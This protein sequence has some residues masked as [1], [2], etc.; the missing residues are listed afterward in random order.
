MEIVYLNGNFMPI[1]QAYI[2]PLDRGFNF[3]DSVYEVIPVYSDTVFAFD[4]HMQRLQQSLSSIRIKNPLK[5]EEWKIVFQELVVKNPYDGDRQIYVQVSRGVAER[6]H[7][8]DDSIKPT[9]FALCKPIQQL[10]TSKGVSA[11]THEDIRWKYCY[12]KSTALLPNILVKVQAQENNNAKEAILLREGKVTEGAASNV[13][14][15][16]DGKISTP[17]KSQFVLPG[18]TRDILVELLNQG[19]LGCYEQEI[20]EDMLR[21]ADEIWITSSTLGVI[22][23]VELDN[24]KINNGNVGPIWEKVST[25]YEQYKQDYKKTDIDGR[26]N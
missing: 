20:T 21:D 2:S 26:Y 22:P 25:L 8:F 3:A 23:V 24:L 19:D 7:L 12:I 13:F 10:E 1:A 17:E 9:V 16:K 5:A 15:C 14:I 6:D 18:I 11:I 4:Q